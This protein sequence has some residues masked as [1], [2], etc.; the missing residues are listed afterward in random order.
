MKPERIVILTG[1]GISAES[2]MGTFRDKDG[3]WT[4]Y[5][6]RDVATPEGFA[7]DPAFV[8]E[9]YAARRGNSHGAEPNAAHFALGKLEQEYKGE[10]L[11]VTQNIDNLHERGGST[12]LLHMHGIMD[13][14][15]CN[16]CGYRAPTGNPLTIESKCPACGTK[17]QMRPDVVWFGEMPY[18]MDEIE[19]ALMKCDVFV[20]IGTSGEVYPA[21]GFVAMARDI[22]AHTV[23]LNLEPSSGDYMFAE[24]RYGMASEVVPAWVEEMLA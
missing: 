10:V 8:L 15:L 12:N 9:F 22:G 4:K 14:D 19:R 13:G 2:G 18:H 3:L 17:G 20:S 16:N 1:A 24:C 6:L 23:E 11:V 21:A 5:D 7:R